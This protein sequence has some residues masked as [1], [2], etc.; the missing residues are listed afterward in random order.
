[1][2]RILVSPGIT[3]DTA[4]GMPLIRGSRPETWPQLA[5]A[6]YLVASTIDRNEHGNAL[7]GL[8]VAQ[9]VISMGVSARLQRTYNVEHHA[10]S[11]GLRLG[12][13]PTHEWSAPAD[14]TLQDNW[15]LAR[16]IHA[17]G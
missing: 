14:V 8:G 10:D 7:R 17:P 2:T 3:I 9:A 4:D 15:S 13:P 11:G 12:R 16:A 1:M 6:L 5:D